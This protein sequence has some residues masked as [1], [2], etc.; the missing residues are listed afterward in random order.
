MKKITHM[1]PDFYRR[2]VQKTKNPIAIGDLLLFSCILRNWKGIV[3]EVFQK[4][5]NSVYKY[6]EIK[7]VK[8]ASLFLEVLEPQLRFLCSMRSAFILHE[9]NKVLRVADVQELARDNGII[10]KTILDIE[11]KLLSVRVGA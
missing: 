8:K 5:E 9:C 3:R 4:E 1:L 7:K 10:E 2:L 6:I 11:L